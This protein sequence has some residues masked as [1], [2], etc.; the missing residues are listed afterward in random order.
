LKEVEASGSVT[1]SR[2]DADTAREVLIAGIGLQAEPL[3]DEPW[4]AKLRK[5]IE[6]PIEEQ[7]PVVLG[8]LRRAGDDTATIGTP[9]TAEDAGNP[10]GWQRRVM[11]GA[12]HGLADRLQSRP[13]D[14]KAWLPLKR[15]CLCLGEQ[16]AAAALER[17]LAAFS[18][19]APMRVRIATGA[20]LLG[21]THD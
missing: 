8:R 11:R 10:V 4:S 1:F 7:K 2:D 20:R 15:A 18:D 16:Q 13:R 6:V 12:A 19:D 5:P 3:G 21:A 17:A 9:A 14:A